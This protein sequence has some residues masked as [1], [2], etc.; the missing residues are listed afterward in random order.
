MQESEGKTNETR[1]VKKL[2]HTVLHQIRRYGFIFSRQ[3]T[4]IRHDVIVMKAQVLAAHLSA[5][6]SQFS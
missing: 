4:F 3:L 6:S 1:A 5:F 2:D